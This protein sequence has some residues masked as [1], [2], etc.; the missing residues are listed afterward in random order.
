M[1]SAP[2]IIVKPASS[3]IVTW[4]DGTPA[5]IAAM[6]AAAD[7]GQITLSDY[8][9][10]GDERT[11]AHA[12]MPAT[13]VGET[14]AAQNQVWVLM[15]TGANSGYVFADDTPV[16]YVVGMKDCFNEAGYMNSTDTNS[17]SWNSC[18]RR[19]WCN[20]ELRNSLD[21]ETQALFKQFKTVTAS[22]NNSDM[23]TTSL[24][25]FSLF[26][27]KEIFGSSVYYSRTAEANA[28]TQIHYYQT[29]ANRVK[30]LSG[31]AY[32][33]WQRSPVK[34]DTTAFCNVYQDGDNVLYSANNTSGISVFGCI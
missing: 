32:R 30:T 19:T 2:T 11:I 14:H 12:A 31:D 4:A 22:N 13:N 34:D 17:G 25:Y 3:K 10:I 8:W 20:N 28:L 1:I 6:L 16:H 18:A 26:A 7:A 33:W 29:S 24:D 15:D 27:E 21:A 23:L 5:E 9:S